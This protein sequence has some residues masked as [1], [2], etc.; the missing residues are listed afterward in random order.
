MVYSSWLRTDR[1]NYQ[2]DQTTHVNASAQECGS[3][4]RVWLLAVS[5]VGSCSSVA[6][7][8]LPGPGRISASGLLAA[9]A[10]Q[11]GPGRHST[12]TAETTAL[13]VFVRP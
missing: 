2:V 10:V 7:D 9:L 13:A 5:A 3:G 6:R 11:R 4:P 1:V 12:I 8:H